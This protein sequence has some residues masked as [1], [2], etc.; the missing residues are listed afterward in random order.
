M[1]VQPTIVDLRAMSPAATS[2]LQFW[3]NNGWKNVKRI[4][5]EIQRLEEGYE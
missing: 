2:A 3:R 1:F 4:E 5:R